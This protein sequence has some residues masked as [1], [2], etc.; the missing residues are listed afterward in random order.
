LTIVLLFA[1][2]G[3]GSG[4]SSGNGVAAK[5]PT[6]IVA[7]AKAAADGA[8]SVHVSGSM[9]SGSTP[10]TLNLNL[11]AGKGGRGQISSNGLSFQ[12]IQTAGTVYISGSPAFYRHF[13]GPS[14]AQL[15]QGKWLKAPANTGEFASIASLTDLR[16]LV[17]AGLANSHGTLTKGATTTIN[18]QKVIAIEDSSKA[19]G[20]LYVATT[21]Q[22]YP[23]EIAKSGT[24]GGKITFGN[25]N[26]SFPISAP[27]NAVDITK[28]KSGH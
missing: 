4:S 24:E 21:G 14:A 16:K 22:P 5:T 11:T 8:S 7:A 27:T 2:T 18:G 6:E 10:L 28:L 9:I 13:A 3:C 19:G 12:L 23:I 25:W 20:T 17:D 26:A 1:L 15:L